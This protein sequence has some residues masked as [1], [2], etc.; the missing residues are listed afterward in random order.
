MAAT[1]S[2]ITVSGRPR[3]MPT[4]R[5]QRIPPRAESAEDPPGGEVVERRE[6]AGQAGG[7]ARPDVDHA[8]ADLDPLGGRGER[9]HRD[10]GVA[11]EPAV[12]LP[13]GAEAG[14]LGLADVLDTVAD[15]VGVLQVQ[16]DRIGVAR[17]RF[18]IAHP[19]PARS[20]R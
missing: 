2:R 5:R 17:H 7:V 13:H 4:L 1:T 9:C 12:R 11:H 8:G 20:G 6:R 10:D 18:S 19:G 16:G 3:S 15:R 14:R